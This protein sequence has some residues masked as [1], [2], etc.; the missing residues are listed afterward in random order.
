MQ[1]RRYDRQ[2]TLF[3][4]TNLM[5]MAGGAI[6]IDVVTNLL[7]LVGDQE[8]GLPIQQLNEIHKLKSDITIVM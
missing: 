4:D 2:Q 3:T 8:M 7:K 6:F 5:L 1:K